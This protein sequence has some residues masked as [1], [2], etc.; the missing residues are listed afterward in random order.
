VF[1]LSMF[2]TAAAELAP[3]QW[4]DFALTRT[5]GMQGIWLLVYISGIMF[6]MR[7]FAGALAHRLSP[8]GVLWVSCLLAA[9]GLFLLSKAN[10]PITAL[11][12]ATVWGTGVCYMWPTML[13]ASSERFP[14][15]GALLM[16]LMGTA[17]TASIWFFLPKMGS[18]YDHVKVS[19]AA[20]QD[21][22]NPVI[23]IFEAIGRGVAAI[24]HI[25]GDAVV[26]PEAKAAFDALSAAAKTDPAKQQVLDGILTQAA[27]VSFQAMAILPALLLV[28]FGAIWLYDRSKGG[29]KP[30]RID[31]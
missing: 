24:L 14:K 16:G 7:H 26:A 4:V 27:S 11:L 17:G 31:A 10:S 30:E 29:Y 15:G 8:V 20:G 12:A 25:G 1:F 28:V 19:L 9:I 22:G 23:L 18:I 6:I 13:A 5:V 2:L 3:G 21:P